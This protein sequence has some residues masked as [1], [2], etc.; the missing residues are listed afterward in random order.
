MMSKVIIYSKDHCPYCDHAKQLLD[1]KSVVYQEIRID[2]DPEQ[3]AKMVALTQRRTVPQIIINDEPV[4]GF[5]DLWALEQAGQ[6]DS[7]LN[8]NK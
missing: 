5:D 4:G 8:A 6:L 2:Q 7:K 3:A 1:K